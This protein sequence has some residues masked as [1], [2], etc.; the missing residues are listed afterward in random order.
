M[1]HVYRVPAADGFTF[2][3]E[4]VILSAQL[5]RGGKVVKGIEPKVSDLT[6]TC[7]SPLVEPGDI[8][9]VEVGLQAMAGAHKGR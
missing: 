2:R 5:V 7:S 6:A 8:L 3:P 1:S 9:E 4:M